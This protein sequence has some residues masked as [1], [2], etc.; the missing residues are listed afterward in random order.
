VFEHAFG[1]APEQMEDVMLP[2]DADA[3]AGLSWRELRVLAASM[4]VV[5]PG[6]V[7]GNGTTDAD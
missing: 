3:I 6:P 7:T 2:T 4:T 5:E 1:R